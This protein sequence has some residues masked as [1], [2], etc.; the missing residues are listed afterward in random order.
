M[1]RGKTRNAYNVGSEEE[2]SIAELARK[3]ANCA[4]SPVDVVTRGSD[5]PAN[6]SR[7]VPRTELIEREYQVENCVSLDDAIKRT[8]RWNEKLN[9]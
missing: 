2:V 7:Y 4:P 5:T 3:V 9:D 8:I 6:T 1:A